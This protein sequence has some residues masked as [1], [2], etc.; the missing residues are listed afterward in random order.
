[1]DHFNPSHLKFYGI[2]IFSVGLLFTVVT[3]YGE[4][5][6]KAPPKVSGLYEI[7]P[8][9]LS[10]CLKSKPL[11]LTIQQ[12]GLHVSGSLQSKSDRSE[13]KSTS[14]KSQTLKG[15]WQDG[16]FSIA[17]AVTDVEGC[18]RTQLLTITATLSGQKLEGNLAFSNNTSAF[19]AQLQESD[20]KSTINH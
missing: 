4:S 19:T 18:D 14:E 7:D 9:N 6:L 3:A 1:M 10:D 17:G 8:K 2:A 13:K 20:L 16:K 15:R 5:N 11:Q 12:S